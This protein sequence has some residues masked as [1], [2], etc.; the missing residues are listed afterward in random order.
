MTHK[1]ALNLADNKEINT[2]CSL[3]LPLGIPSIIN[4]AK[5]NE[6]FIALN[7]CPIKCSSLALQ[8][9]G[10]TGFREL[11]LTDDFGIQENKN[12]K[13]EIKMT[14]VEAATRKMIGEIQSE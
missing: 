14:Q 5:M 11:T 2:V 4:M 9:V 12:F 6:K 1:I 10:I 3:G 7:G 8:K 13:D